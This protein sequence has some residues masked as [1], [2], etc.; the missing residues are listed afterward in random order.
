MPIAGNMLSAEMLI[1]YKNKYSICEQ[2]SVWEKLCYINK[3]NIQ[4]NS[5]MWI[6]WKV[7]GKIFAVEKLWHQPT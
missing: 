4:F 6:F 3:Y 2:E 7:A 5:A 1:Q